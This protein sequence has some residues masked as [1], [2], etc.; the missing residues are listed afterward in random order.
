MITILI[1]DAL[2][3]LKKLNSGSVNCC[4]TSPPYFGLRDYGID[5]QIGLESTPEEYVC[6][7][8][9]IFSEVRRVL[10]VDGT[11]W[12]NMGD[13]YSNTKPKPLQDGWMNTTGPLNWTNNQCRNLSS[14][15]AKNLLGM[16]WRVAFA[17]Q[18]DGWYLR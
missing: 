7:T 11:L 15:P 16:P 9:E 8:V 2:T 3:E 1:G 14:L 6:K 12:L 10:R 5:G 17:L 18:A 4:V 13:S